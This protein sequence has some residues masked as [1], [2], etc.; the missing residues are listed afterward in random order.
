MGEIKIRNLSDDVLLRLSYLAKEKGMSRE[1]Y[2]RKY[3]E[4]LS[5]LG[6][7]KDIEGRYQTL[8]LKVVEAI[9]FNTHQ[10]ASINER[11]ELL[12][13]SSLATVNEDNDID[14]EDKED[15]SWRSIKWQK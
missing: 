15:I 4:S 1:N 7:L 2:V 13:H 11:L 8:V 3:L 14:S 10:L 12:E 9:E 5:V 6:E